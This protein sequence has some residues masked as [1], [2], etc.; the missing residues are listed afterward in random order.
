MHSLHHGS[1]LFITTAALT[2][3]GITLADLTP[4]AFLRYVWESRDHSLAFKGH[5]DAG[6]SQFPGS[7]PG[8]CCTTW[9]FSIR[10]PGDAAR[11]RAQ[12]VSYGPGVGRPLRQE[13][14]RVLRRRCLRVG[15]TGCAD[16]PSGTPTRASSLA[17]SSSGGPRTRASVSSPRNA[18]AS[19]ARGSTS[20]RDPH[21]VNN[22]RTS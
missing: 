9:A 4:E 10:H 17:K 5:S 8:R 19:P 16:G 2:T 7:W 12:L 20:L 1:A 22:T 18:T 21:V 15:D 11:G 14:E 6:R 3:P 13:P